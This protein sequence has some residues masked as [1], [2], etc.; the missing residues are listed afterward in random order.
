MISPEWVLLLGTLARGGAVLLALMLFARLVVSPTLG[1]LRESAG[2]QLPARVSDLEA[3]MAGALPAAGSQ[4]PVLDQ[5]A[6]AA[7]MRKEEGVRTL[8]NWLD[9]G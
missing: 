3:E 8:R 4:T 5:A 1:A 9:Q 6:Q 2:T 7:N